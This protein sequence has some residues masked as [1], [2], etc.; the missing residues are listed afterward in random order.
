MLKDEYPEE[1]TN[2]LNDDG[3]LS[4]FKLVKL[5]IK[6]RIQVNPTMSLDDLDKL[7]TNKLKESNNGGKLIEQNLNVPIDPL[8]EKL[9]DVNNVSN[10]ELLKVYNGLKKFYNFLKTR[11]SKTCNIYLT[12][13]LQDIILLSPDPET[14]NFV[15]FKKL[16][17]W[18]D[19]L[20]LGFKSN[21]V[22]NDKWQKM[23]YD[24]Q[25][26]I[27]RISHKL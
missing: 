17:E 5:A 6:L 11:D 22:P 14:N 19:Y 26:I 10:Q 24:T 3:S 7:I 13:K 9:F 4:K 18:Q 25:F 8:K 20:D 27:A 2:L 23:E 21:G 16:Q 1:Y 15:D 12:N